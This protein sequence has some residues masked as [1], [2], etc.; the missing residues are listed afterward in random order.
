M[1]YHAFANTLKAGC[2]TGYMVKDLAMVVHAASS[3]DWKGTGEGVAQIADRLGEGVGGM[4]TYVWQQLQLRSEQ[5]RCSLGMNGLHYTLI[6]AWKGHRQI[7]TSNN[8]FE[9]ASTLLPLPP[10]PRD[11]D[12]N[13]IRSESKD[14]SWYQ[15]GLAWFTGDDGEDASQAHDIEN[16][17]ERSND[18][19]LTLLHVDIVNHL[20]NAVD[21]CPSNQIASYR[22]EFITPQNM[23]DVITDEQ[24]YTGSHEK[25][26]VPIKT[27]FDCDQQIYAKSRKLATAISVCAPVAGLCVAWRTVDM[28]NTW[29]NPIAWPHKITDSCLSSVTGGY[30]Q[31]VPLHNLLS[32]TIVLTIGLWLLKRFGKVLCGKKDS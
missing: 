17:R 29:L 6:H 24:K 28:F 30:W 8:L 12:G 27:N 15:A 11:Q 21:G 10:L 1:G 22:M 20:V 16:P 14:K 9:D 2:W 7:R 32:F 18:R 31:S 13:V 3:E 4:T 26:I 23:L 19:T 25:V 5:T